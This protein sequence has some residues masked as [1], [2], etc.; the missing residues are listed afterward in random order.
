MFEGL[1]DYWKTIDLG[2]E[3][4]LVHESDK[5]LEEDNNQ[6]LEEY[7]LH[8]ELFPEPFNGNLRDPKIVFLFLNPGYNKAD[9]GVKERDDFRADVKKAFCQNYTD[10]DKY[11]FLWLNPEYNQ[12]NDGYTRREVNERNGCNP[13]AYYWN[14]LFDQKTGK[15]FMKNL[16]DEYQEPFCEKTRISI[17]NNYHEAR[18]WI[19]HNVCDIELFPYHSKKFHYSFSSC[20][21]S[22]V[23]RCN[24]FKEIKD[25]DDVL[26]IFMRSINLWTKGCDE[27]EKLLKKSNVIINPCPR[28]PSLNP[29]KSLGSM[30]VKYLLPKRFN[31]NA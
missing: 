10:K 14:K 31:Q 21:S 27:W 2:K 19:A 9:N 5:N 13:G 12:C 4:D 3:N 16:Y 28:N 20:R 18:E 1:I 8:F 26:F 30:I 11:P 23:A 29:D 7:K 6:R 22:E 25:H 24:V 17:A 15:S